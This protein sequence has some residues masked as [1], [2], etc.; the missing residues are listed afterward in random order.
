[1]NKSFSI[2]I[3]ITPQSAI[4]IVLFAII[5]ILLFYLSTLRQIG[6]YG[7]ET[8]FY[9]GFVPNAQHLLAGIPLTIDWQ[10]PLY[11]TVLA[12]VYSCI[13]DWFRS[14]LLISVF[15]GILVLVAVYRVFRDI[16]GNGAAVAATMALA[17]WPEF[18]Q[19]SITA[20]SD[21]LFLSLMMLSLAIAVS[22]DRLTARRAFMA[23]IIAALASL[24]R[25]N[26]I[27]L[28]TIA[29]ICGG[30]MV[31]GQRL[32]P[33][34]TCLAGFALPWVLW[35]TLAGVSGSPVF[36]TRTYVDIAVTFFNSDGFNSSSNSDYW[37]LVNA[38]VSSFADVLFYDP[39][40]LVTGFARNLLRN[41][42]SLFDS[43]SV[44][45]LPF[46]GI[47]TFGIAYLALQKRDGLRL[48][49]WLVLLSQYAI[50]G[51]RSFNSRYYLFLVPLMGVGAYVAGS[52]LISSVRIS[53]KA[54]MA[55]IGIVLS[56][57]VV[58]MVIVQKRHLDWLLNQDATDVVAASSVL[59]QMSRP[60]DRIISR[61]PHLAFQAGLVN[62][63]FPLAETTADLYRE[64]CP[65]PPTTKTFLFYGKAESDL[66]PAL[67][68]L[69][70]PDNAPE[71]LIP[72]G[73]GETINASWA[74]YRVQC[75]DGLNPPPP[76]KSP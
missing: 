39:R 65:I 63:G 11:P 49:F 25:T 26:G 69:R 55:L 24:T 28:L 47:I 1:M 67:R 41:W 53:A 7:V 48:A 38:K 43:I 42:W 13:H 40:V 6:N 35:A 15:S 3:K 72:I 76:A 32:R 50:L 33:F 12:A 59:R 21:M 58:L 27:T 73:N 45:L 20:S 10:P 60:D 34:L 2:P 64:V 31:A 9:G 22:G 44:R 56:V 37:Q 75:S 29:L 54:R 74:L 18:L 71:W 14:G 5:G 46:A 68:F 57:A 17:A 61:K 16:F 66:R 19:Y 51:L 8:D 70:A 36:P 23:G 4:M 52:L 62:V 30:R